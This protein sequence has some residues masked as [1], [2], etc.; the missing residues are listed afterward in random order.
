MV[1]LASFM[2]FGK[3]QGTNL[4]ASRVSDNTGLAF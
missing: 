3:L 2:G 1:T 4:K